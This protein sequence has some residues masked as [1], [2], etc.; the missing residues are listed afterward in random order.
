MVLVAVSLRG[1]G[2]AHVRLTDQDGPSASLKHKLSTRCIK[3]NP[4][5]KQRIFQIMRVVFLATM[6]IHIQA[7]CVFSLAI[8]HF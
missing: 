7:M 2:Y 1:N 4:W 6:I 5:V 8:N 3:Q